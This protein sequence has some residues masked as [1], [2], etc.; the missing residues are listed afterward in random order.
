M[1]WALHWHRVCMCMCFMLNYVREYIFSNLLSYNIQTVSAHHSSHS[2]SSFIHLNARHNIKI[3][4]LRRREYDA[5]C[6]SI[7]AVNHHRNP[8]CVHMCEWQN[9]KLCCPLKIRE[10]GA[11]K[12]HPTPT[13]SRESHPSVFRCMLNSNTVCVVACLVCTADAWRFE[14]ACSTSPGCQGIEDATSRAALRSVFVI[15]SGC[16]CVCLL[17]VYGW[18]WKTAVVL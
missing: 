3:F 12:S 15:E 1:W 6:G 11:S 18:H 14:R 7:F 10:Q 2:H 16:E 13:M 5:Q 4:L 8:R 17:W 9:L